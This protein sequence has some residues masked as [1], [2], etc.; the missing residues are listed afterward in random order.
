LGQD[1]MNILSNFYFPRAAQ[2]TTTAPARFPSCLRAFVVK[3]P[4]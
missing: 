3:Y 1:S 2:I 4:G